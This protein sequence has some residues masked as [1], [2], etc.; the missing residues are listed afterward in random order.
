MFVTYGY[1]VFGMHAGWGRIINMSSVNG[2]VG[3]AN[4]SV[5]TAS[6]HGLC[7]LTKVTAISYVVEFSLN[8]ELKLFIGRLLRS[9]HLM[10]WSHC[11]TRAP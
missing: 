8:L 2:V 6:K 1:D 7:G 5:Y 11:K 3:S 9:E 10:R 4:E